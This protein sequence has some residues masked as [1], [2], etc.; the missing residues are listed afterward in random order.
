MKERGE[1]MTSIKYSIAKRNLFQQFSWKRTMMM[2]PFVLCCFFPEPICRSCILI[3]MLCCLVQRHP[4]LYLTCM[5]VS[6]L[7]TAIFQIENLPMLLIMLTFL[8]LLFQGIVLTNLNRFTSLP[9]LAAISISVEMMLRLYDFQH[10]FLSAIVVG[11][12]TYF[13]DKDNGAVLED[14]YLIKS[15]LLILLCIPSFF[16]IENS[17]GMILFVFGATLASYLLDLRTFICILTLSVL[18]TFKESGIILFVIFALSSCIPAH[19]SKIRMLVTSILL[20]IYKTDI[21]S[22]IYVLSVF[23]GT[24][25]IKKIYVNRTEEEN[26]SLPL[27]RQ[28]SDCAFQLQ[29]FSKIFEC[30]ADHYKST[31]L[32]TELMTSMG[33]TLYSMSLQLKSSSQSTNALHQKIMQT[34][35]GYKFEISRLYIE[36]NKEGGIC[37]KL[38]C[39][40]CSKQEINTIL[41]PLL[42]K[43]VHKKLKITSI[44]KNRAMN[45]FVILECSSVECC[46]LQVHPYSFSKEKASG[47]QYSI[48]EYKDQTCVILSDGMGCGFQAQEESLFL[49]ELAQRMIACQMPL[50]LIAGN[51][52]ECMAMSRK[53]KFATLDFLCFDRSNKEAYMV[54]SGSCPTYL[55]RNK[56]VLEIK[57][58]GLPLGII[59]K[60]KPDCFKIACRKGDIFVMVSD[61]VEASL[62][63]K[64]L[65]EDKGKLEENIKLAMKKPKG[66]FKDDAT[67]LLVQV[68]SS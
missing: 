14:S 12:C 34:L 20:L 65:K 63:E 46:K 54:K 49:I 51:I 39:A 4:V 28:A 68:Q 37:L 41:V 45:G 62:L 7:T 36:E 10:V 25:L 43:C 47:D 52:N 8:N 58:E 42:E 59:Q 21:Q 64:W 26:I 56:C 24:V 3:S 27:D 18:F 1:F 53:E 30:M 17:F 6:V 35:E 19:K 5:L 40:K 55:I 9:F 29:Q 48:F 23:L 13:L 67:I 11:Y 16:A 2:I 31:P 60:I 57:G 32:E 22:G 66:Q 50:S 33:K 61:G 44:V 15:F 38:H